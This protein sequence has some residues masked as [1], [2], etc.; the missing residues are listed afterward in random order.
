MTLPWQVR[1]SLQSLAT[2]AAALA[3]TPGVLA[4]LIP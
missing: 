4:Q 2:P 1:R 3:M